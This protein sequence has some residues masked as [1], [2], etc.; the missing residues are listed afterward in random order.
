V[1][2]R[3]SVKGVTWEWHQGLRHQQQ[4]RQI[5]TGVLLYRI[6]GCCDCRQFDRWSWWSSA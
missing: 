4:L 3:L 5:A 1:A 2:N 6:R